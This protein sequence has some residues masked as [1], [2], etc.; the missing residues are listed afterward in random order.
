MDKNMWMIRAGEDAF[1]IDDF[2]DKNIVAIG[3]NY[4]GDLKK[5]Q[6][7]E[8]IKDQIKKENPAYNIYKIGRAAGQIFTFIHEI[9][10]GDYAITYD[11][12]N[13]EYHIGKIQT[14]YKLKPKLCEYQNIRE[15]KWIGTVNRD[16]LST[17]AKYKLGAINTIFKVHE[18]FVD[19]ILDLLKGKD[20]KK[21]DIEEQKSEI[22]TIKEDYIAISHEFI[23]DKIIA[24]SWEDMQELVAGVLRGM[25]YKTMVSP[26]GPDRGKDITASPDGLGLTQP[27]IFIEVKHR[28]GQI[29]AGEIRKF[30]GGLRSGS[31]G[32]Y[33]STGGFAKDAKYE[34][35]RSNIPL[36]L[37]DTDLLV[38]LIIEYYNN[39]DPDTR[40][41]LPL[42]KMYWPS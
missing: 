25:G 21:E 40:A 26:K 32:I 13:R 28:S 16:K 33:V 15:V 6:S 24:L 38:D 14:D 2:K 4:L 1:L 20:E 8:E 9:S 22:D 7:K 42:T 31:N 10:I 5:F 39:F 12:D 19:E 17:S 23:K 37:V 34:A 35:E 27:R 30:I 18:D 11:P 41:L 29:G 3:W 36:T